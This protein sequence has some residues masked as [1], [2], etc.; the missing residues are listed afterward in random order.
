MPIRTIRASGTPRTTGSPGAP[1]SAPGES[2]TTTK[3]RARRAGL[4]GESTWGW[5][6]VSPMVL[7]LSLFMVLPILMALWVSLLHWDGQSNPFSGQADFVG[8]DNYR[9]LLTQDGLDRTL[10][11]TAL[12]NNLYYVLLTVPLQTGLALGLA[13]IVNQR[14]LRG[15]GALRTTFFLPSVTSSI[16]VST[17]FLFL[18]QGSGAVNSILSWIGVKGPNWFADPRG[19]LSLILG[20]LGIVDPERPTGMLADHSM[21]GLSWFEWLSGPSVAMC[22]LVVLAVWTTSG[23][24]MLIFLAALQ[25]IPRELEESAAMEGVN[26]RQMLR[27][28]TLPALRP[29]LFLVLTLGLISTWQVFDQ[30]YVMGQGAPGNTTLTPAFLSYS[31][32]FDNAD[33]GQG[34]AI[35]FILLALILVLTVFQRWALRERGVRTGRNR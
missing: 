33:F 23:S 1:D 21:L 18:F 29:V 11:A 6:F 24:F 4:R 35:A 16:A 10:F 26:R 2:G 3:V 25:N 5:L 34:A 31:A 7:V 13:L 9:S 15:R 22:T 19:V 27:Y 17:V 30:V 28:V 14:L 12:R 8:L 20:G 32:G